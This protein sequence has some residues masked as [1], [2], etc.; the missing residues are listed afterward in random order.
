MVNENF[1]VHAN[2]VAQGEEP[3]WVRDSLSRA[4][5]L[6]EWQRVPRTQRAMFE[7]LCLLGFQNGLW[8]SVVL[9]KRESICKRFKGFSLQ[10]VASLTEHEIS[11]MLSDKSMIRNEAKIR[12]CIANAQILLK[13]SIN[14]PELF[15]Q[16]FGSSA[17]FELASELP[18]TFEA[19]DEIADYL[20]T[21]GVQRAGR[22]V[23]CALAQATG[24]IKLGT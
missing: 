3:S 12:S 9:G 13:N 22:V 6:E 5:F 23:C 10:A 17:T 11:Q 19:T 20:K 1:E 16:T 8:W 2:S 7:H 4:Y 15:E 14:L 18:K 24:F 21:T